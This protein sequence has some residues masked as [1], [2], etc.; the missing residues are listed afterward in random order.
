MAHL[1]SDP[2]GHVGR[3]LL[4]RWAQRG[5]GSTATAI[6]AFGEDDAFSIQLDLSARRR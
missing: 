2:F 5:V 6:D 1:R 4:R 3:P